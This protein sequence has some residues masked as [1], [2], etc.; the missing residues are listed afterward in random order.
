M[1]NAMSYTVVWHTLSVVCF[2]STRSWLSFQGGR[3]FLPLLMDGGIL[4]WSVY[5]SVASSM[6]AAH[7][8]D[9]KMLPVLLPSHGTP[10]LAPGCLHHATIACVQQLVHSLPMTRRLSSHPQGAENTPFRSAYQRSCVAVWS[11]MTA[12]RNGWASEQ[13]EQWH[14][15]SFAPDVLPAGL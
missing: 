4:E 1:P 6:T 13:A 2:N 3:R 10:V 8:S 7:A 14:W 9:Y 12:G 11:V 15:N 5:A